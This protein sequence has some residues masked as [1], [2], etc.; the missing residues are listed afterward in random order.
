MTIKDILVKIETGEMSPKALSL[1]DLDR[2][3]YD[4]NKKRPSDSIEK[5]KSLIEAIKSYYNDT[6]TKERGS[7]KGSPEESGKDQEAVEGRTADE[8][9][10]SQSGISSVD[11]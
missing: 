9:S 7:S 6:S 5:Q 10:V 4:L 2:L 3:L 11:N 8:G 1:A